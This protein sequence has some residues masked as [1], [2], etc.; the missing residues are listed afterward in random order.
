MIYDSAR[1]ASGFDPA[2]ASFVV[3]VHLDLQSRSD[4]ARIPGA[5]TRMSVVQV[6]AREKLQPD[7]V[8]VIVPDRRL[9]I[10]DDRIS[11]TEIDKPRGQRTA[12]D[13]FFRSL[14]ERIGDGFAI[15]PTGSG[16][17]GAIGV[18]VSKDA[19]GIVLVPDPEESEY[20]SMPRSAIV[21]GVADFVVPL[22]E[23]AGWLVELLAQKQSRTEECQ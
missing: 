4:L 23:L 10:I 5:R 14:G 9:E 17:H 7:H 11:A 1:D 18:R 3:I 12:I 2:G 19:G 21:T 22:R 16:S 15:I 13:Q 8:Y 6:Q 20:P